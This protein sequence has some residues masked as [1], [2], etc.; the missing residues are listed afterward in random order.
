M[1]LLEAHLAQLILTD[2]DDVAGCGI[3]AEAPITVN[4]ADA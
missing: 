2:V 1:G 4:V 3:E